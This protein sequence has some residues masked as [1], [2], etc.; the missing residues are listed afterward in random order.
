[1]RVRHLLIVILT[2][3]FAY[4]WLDHR[5]PVRA[6]QGDGSYA[7]PG[8]AIEA[9]ESIEMSGR[10]LSL[11]SYR[12]GREAEL[13]PMDIALGWGPMAEASTL[14]ELDLSQ[15]NRWV[16]WRADRL[17]IPRK[18]IDT[19]MANVH[20]IPSNPWISDQLE[21]LVI[22]SEI[23]LIGELVAVTGDDGWRWRSSLSRADTGAGSCE[24]LWLKEIRVH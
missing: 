13:S 20:I 22:D 10:V 23:T 14:A 7:Y 19:N 17:P 11:R 24:L 21:Q 6:L 9:L 3:F 2:T 16:F 4:R 15:R 1:M 8:Y 12:T 18:Q 5:D